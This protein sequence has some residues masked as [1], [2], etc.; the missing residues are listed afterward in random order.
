M[1]RDYD[2][3]RGQQRVKY[4]R[5]KS[6]G[7]KWIKK[8]LELAKKQRK[9]VPS[10]RVNHYKQNAKNRKIEWALSDEQAVFMM[11][12]PCHYCGVPGQDLNGIDRKDSTGAYEPMNTLPCC[13]ICNYAKRSLSYPEFMAWVDRIVKFRKNEM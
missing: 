8:K 9:M 4:W 11:R 7:G 12:S 5:D 10:R 2:H 6:N 13:S 3:E 1:P